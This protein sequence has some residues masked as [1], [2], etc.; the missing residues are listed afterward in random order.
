[1]TLMEFTMFPIDKGSSLSTYV[2]AVLDIVDKSGLDYRLTPMG[3]VVEGEW[4]DLLSLLDRCFQATQGFSDRISLSVR[5]DY[6]K[7]RSGGMLSKIASVE[8]KIGR[9]LKSL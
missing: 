8:R 2:A 6:R 5:F 7:D 3:T 1:M 4:P 9:K